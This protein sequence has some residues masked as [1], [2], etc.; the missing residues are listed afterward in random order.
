M[1][2][3]F[4]HLLLIG[5]H[6]LFHSFFLDDKLP[7][8][9]LSYSDPLGLEMAFIKG[10]SFMMG[11]STPYYHAELPA[12]R[13]EVPDFYLGKYEVTRAL[14]TRV[15]EVSPQTSA[16]CLSCPIDNI[17][18][19]EV[20]LFITLLNRNSIYQYRLP[21][22]AEWEYAAGNGRRHTLF[23]W[24]SL[25]PKGKNGGNVSGT[26]TEKLFADQ[27]FFNG[28]KDGYSRLAPVGK[29]N[30]NSFGLYDMTG[31]VFEYC[32]DNFHYSFKGAPSDG[33][34]WVHP[35]SSSVVIKGGGFFS[36]TPTSRVSYRRGFLAD[37]VGEG[38]GFRLART[39]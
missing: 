39:K 8:A 14:W 32:Q 26:D 22:E 21:T 15:M 17:S 2:T 34:V 13:V 20:Q 29:F 23:S 36:G 35:D 5:I 12:H 31:N 24:G 25:G 9:E 28:Y 1:L 7:E 30:P 4:I 3:Q 16:D 27:H 6:F 33:S 11:S 19:E 18:W 37:Y 38:L 10:G